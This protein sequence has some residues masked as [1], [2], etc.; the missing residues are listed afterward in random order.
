MSLT[1]LG[2][3][4]EAQDNPGLEAPDSQEI[5]VSRDGHRDTAKHSAAH[6]HRMAKVFRKADNLDMV[7]SVG[8]LERFWFL[9]EY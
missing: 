7:M 1:R 4:E 8:Y 2:P 3:G 9:L 6:K 5:P